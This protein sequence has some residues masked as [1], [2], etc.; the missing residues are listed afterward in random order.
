MSYHEILKE[1]VF[2][3][4]AMWE[5][6]EKKCV[7]CGCALIPKNAE[8]DHILPDNLSLEKVKNSNDEDLKRYLKELEDKKF[9]K[10]SI[11]NYFLCFS[12]CNKRKT[13]IPFKTSNLRFFHELASRKAEKIWEKY[14]KKSQI[15]GVEKSVIL[16]PSNIEPNKYNEEDLKIEYECFNNGDRMVFHYGLGEVRIDAYL[17]IRYNDKMC[18]MVYFRSLYQTD[19]DIGFDE[20]DIVA[21]LFEG[22]SSRKNAYE[23][24]WCRV[25]KTLEDEK[26]YV[27]NLPNVMIKA[28]T[29][30]VKQFA[31]II[32][33]LFDDYI[34]QKEIIRAELGAENFPE[35]KEKGGSYKILELE[36]NFFAEFLKF[37]K[38]HPYDGEDKPYNIFQVYPD[39][40][41]VALRRNVDS[42]EDAE[43]YAYLKFIPKMEGYIDVIWQPGMY[44][45][46]GESERMK[47]FDNRKKWTAQYVHDWLV[48]ELFAVILSEMKQE[49][50][51]LL[52]FIFSNRYGV[53][54]TVSDA[55]RRGWIKSYSDEGMENNYKP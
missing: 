3:R 51:S 32:D 46:I 1:N 43:I 44:R 5:V 42:N 28:S 41:M 7:Y 16:Q 39:P 34:V 24:S 22:C 14:E 11:E 38:K 26:F 37:M 12:Y 20:E 23:R 25:R 10:N 2:I 13:N 48:G 35:Y 21:I 49:K 50:V 36:M 4:T 45:P 31:Q 40:D 55:V 54:Y 52:Q 27:M 29:D 8:V 19:I 33:R 30:M 17:P 6:Y 47:Y 18:C 9:V 53:K 15:S